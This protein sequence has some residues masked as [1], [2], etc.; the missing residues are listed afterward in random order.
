MTHLQRNNVAAIL[1]TLLVFGIY[2]LRLPGQIASGRFDGPDGFAELGGSVLWLIGTGIVVTI[3]VTILTSIIY[4]I[5]T[6][7]PKPSFVIDERDRLIELRGV[8][9]MAMASGISFVFAMMAL[10]LGYS[11]FSAFH[12][13]IFG[14][15]FGSLADNALQFFF[16]QR[17]F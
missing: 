11:P 15:A 12:I 17:G 8:K 2:A 16:Q 10:A 9:V 3:V 13:I 7:Q 6:N 1:S 4:A 5:A 14:F